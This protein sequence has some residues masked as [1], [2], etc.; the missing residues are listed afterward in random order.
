M[1]NLNNNN[2]RNRIIEI[3]YAELNGVSMVDYPG[4]YVSCFGTFEKM[5]Y[6]TAELVE[7]E[8]VNGDQIEQ[9]FSIISRGL[10]SELDIILSQI[11]GKYLVFKLVYENGEIKIL[12]TK[13]NPVVLSRESSGSPVSNTLSC[14]RNC[15]ETAKYLL[16]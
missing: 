13:D 2:K 9:N 11:T 6:S 15:A 14:K 12:G 10:S 4:N 3:W 5:R 8:S 16:P 7:S 1:I